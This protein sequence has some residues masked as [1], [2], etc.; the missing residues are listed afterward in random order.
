MGMRNEALSACS[1][2][3]GRDENRDEIVGLVE[4][5]RCVGRQAE[6]V[7]KPQPVE[8]LAELFVGCGPRRVVSIP[9]SH[10]L[11][12]C[13]SSP[14]SKMLGALVLAALGCARG[15]PPTW[16][17]APGSLSVAPL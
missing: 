12:P 3:R 7:G 10:S 16:D 9:H 11:F 8:C 13:S 2:A 17:A 5:G 1:R 4:D 15:E 6:R 14:V